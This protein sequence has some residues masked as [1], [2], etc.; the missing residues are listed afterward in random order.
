MIPA[1]RSAGVIGSCIRI[2]LVFDRQIAVPVVRLAKATGPYMFE[3]MDWIRR[4]LVLAPA[5]SVGIQLSGGRGVDARPASSAASA[6]TGRLQSL[7]NA[8]FAAGGG[9]VDIP[10][11][12]NSL[13]P[14]SLPSGVVLKGAGRGATKLAY[15]GPA[16]IPAV[17]IAN[18][19]IEYIGIHALTLQRADQA[20]GVG[21]DFTGKSSPTG[22]PHG[23]LWWSNFSD[24]EVLDFDCGLNLRGGGADFMIP[25]QFVS[26]D[27]VY[28]RGS[29]TQA[30]V[31]ILGQ[32]N[33]IRFRDS[34]FECRK[35]APANRL[36]LVEMGPT[37]NDSPAP[38]LVLFDQCTFQEGGVAISAT[39]VQGLAI[40]SSWFENNGL[41]VTVQETAGLEVRGNRFANAGS[42]GVAIA[43]DASST[44]TVEDNVFAGKETPKSVSSGDDAKVKQ[45]GNVAVW[46]AKL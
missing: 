43:T 26:F 38:K 29:G 23:G 30:T 21:L 44:A 20:G 32:S 10:A 27:R 4:M 19:P 18:G 34:M 9:V 24:I 42:K 25:N 37:S 2:T 40:R 13:L 45:S 35:G 8:R 31:S 11:G 33:Q 28:V 17:T 14:I 41:S 1:Y 12:Q 39:K 7:I 16:N 5:A 46:G 22:K 15:V 3:T 36:P 6:F